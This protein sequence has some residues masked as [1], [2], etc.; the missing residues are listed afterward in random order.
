MGVKSHQIFSSVYDVFEKNADVRSESKSES[1]AAQIGGP[2]AAMYLLGN[3]DHY[4]SHYFVPFY[5][6]PY[7]TDVLQAWEV[8]MTQ[9]KESYAET[10]QQLTIASSFD[11]SGCKDKDPGEQLALEEDS[12]D[13]EDKVVITRQEPRLQQIVMNMN[14]RYECYDA[15][16]D[17]HSQL[18]AQV[19]AQVSADNADMTGIDEENF[20]VADGVDTVDSFNDMVGTWTQRKLKQMMDIEQGLH[21][22]GWEPQAQ[23]IWKMIWMSNLNL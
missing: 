2:M 19:A 12:N 5:W 3:P 6:K 23:E 15:R 1:D 22:A 17:F 11:T 21:N 9:Y 13:C 20:V 16:D 10:Q 8:V 14:I 4:T 18:K 7:V